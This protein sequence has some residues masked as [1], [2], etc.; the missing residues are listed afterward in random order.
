[1]ASDPDVAAATTTE[2]VAAAAQSREAAATR[3]RGPLPQVVPLS[4]ET[5]RFSVSPAIERIPVSPHLRRRGEPLYR[6]LRIYAIDPAASRLEGAIATI[7]VPWEPLQPG[8]AGSLFVVDNRDLSLG[9]VYRCADLDDPNVLRADG[10]APSPSDPR[11]HQQMVY[12]VCCNVYAAFRKALGRNP[13]W[14]FGDPAAPGPARLVLRPHG[15][16]ER[17]AWYENHGTYGALCFGYYAA[18]DAPSDRTLPRGIVFTAPDGNLQV[19]TTGNQGSGVLSSM[20][21]ANGLIVL[22]HEQGDVAMGDLVDVMMFD[23]AM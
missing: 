10:Y 12:A 5:P 18:A 2:A 21:R 15:G 23:A 6:P 14:G 3:P 9:T 20:V 19:R 17:N 22:R 8:P 13:E 11:F 7:D 16:E 4:I 1:M